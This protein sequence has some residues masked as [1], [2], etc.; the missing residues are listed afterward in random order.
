MSKEMLVTA[1]EVFCPIGLDLVQTSTSVVTGVSCVEFSSIVDEKSAPITMGLVPEDLM[2]KLREKIGSKPSLPS[3]S[4]RMLRLLSPC[5]EHL[6]ASQL[7]LRDMP[8][9]LAGPE[10]QP[11]EQSLLHEQFFEHL[12]LQSGVSF[13]WM[14][15]R[16]F[17]LGR[18]GLFYALNEAEAALDKVDHVLIGG[19]DSMFD[20]LVI[21]RYLSEN[22][23]SREGVMD[24]F[25]PGEGAAL[26]VV[27]NRSAARSLQHEPLA[28]IN[29]WGVGRAEG[30]RYSDLPYRGEGLS[31]AVSRMFEAA[32][33][34]SPITTVFAGL[35]GESFSAK[36]WSVAF[37][38]NRERFR[39][40]IQ[41]E[42]PA[43]YMGDAGA[44]S[45]PISA[46]VAAFGLNRKIWEGPLMLW[47]SSDHAERGVALMSR[48]DE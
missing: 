37:M 20:R 5:L 34:R 23:I 41:L 27:S 47:A 25:T 19:V 42:H 21:A 4:A 9:F 1:A 11:G 22:R 17:R 46:A 15:S 40:D 26:M 30:H 48:L 33:N 36:E 7:P 43:E 13:D 29:S 3:L 44:A 28:V 10:E 32:G 14:K 12:Y 24:G 38:R 45:A 2:A 16:S 39:E 6:D 8:M 31:L 35:N 18:A